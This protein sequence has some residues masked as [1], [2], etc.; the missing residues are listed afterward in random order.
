MSSR[1]PRRVA[2]L[3]GGMSAEREVSLVS[4]QRCGEALQEAG[5]SVIEV[6]AGIDLCGRLSDIGPDV[7]F[8]GLH[9]KWG[10]DGSVQGLLEWM[11]IPYTHSGVR[12]SATAM[13]KVAAR[14]V[15]MQSGLPVPDGMTVGAAELAGGH[16]I[17]PP[18]VVKPVNEGSSVGVVIVPDGANSPVRDYDPQYPEVLVE[19]FIAGRELTVTVLGDRALTVTDIE[20][21]SWYDYHSKYSVGASRHIVPAQLPPEIHDAC[22][23]TALAAHE[24]IGC[25]SISR[26]DFRWDSTRGLD[27]LALLEINTQPGMTPTSLS[28]EQARHCGIGFS[29]LCRMLVEDAS[30]MR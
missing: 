7:V 19:R 15:F 20:T 10:E 22:M 16:P 23:D 13:D 2:V 14:Q 29:D 27:G 21:D 30:C 18:Y 6:D 4:G 5:Y 3:M 24:S 1:T 17:D 25:R 9:G 8:N 28:P 12:A 11:Q 26:A